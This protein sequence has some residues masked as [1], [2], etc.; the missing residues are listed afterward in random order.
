MQAGFAML[1]A[2]I[3]HP[4]NITN[5]LFKVRFRFWLLYLQFLVD[6]LLILQSKTC[7]R[8]Y[9]PSHAGPPSS[10]PQALL[11][12]VICLSR[13]TPSH[14]ACASPQNILDASIA[15]LCWWLLGYGFAYG[16]DVTGFIGKD[17][18]A[19]NVSALPSP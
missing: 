16:T 19:N 10:S 18:F 11:A 4:K 12:C 6:N 5:I 7:F 14:T 17:M 3:V 8:C 2:G 1:E 13:A 15:A 9:P